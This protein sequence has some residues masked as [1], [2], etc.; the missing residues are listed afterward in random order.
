MS[1][2]IL[3]GVISAR[4]IPSKPACARAK[5]GRVCAGLEIIRP[6]YLPQSAMGKATRYTLEIW[7]QLLGYL[8]DGRI[9]I[10]NN[11]VENAIRPTAL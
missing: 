10:D 9:E 11:L 7:D 2:H 1:L 5:P 4:S 8:E 6:R 3:A